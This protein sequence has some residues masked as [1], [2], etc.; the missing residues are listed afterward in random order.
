MDLEYFVGAGTHIKQN[1]VFSIGYMN[2][3][4]LS[5]DPSNVKVL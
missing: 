3:Q 1:P 5:L 2:N 4:F